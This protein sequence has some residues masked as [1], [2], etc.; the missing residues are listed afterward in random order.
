MRGRPASAITPGSP[1]DRTIG[2]FCIRK[3]MSIS[4][5]Y[6]MPEDVRDKLVT[7]YGPRTMRITPAAEAAFDKA[8]ANPTSTEQRL[9]NKLKA[10]RVAKAR[11]AA[12]ASLLGP[13]H[14][15]KKRKRKSPT[16]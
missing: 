4:G 13:N 3:T 6:R 12:Q 11:K 10:R 7:V 5:F 8:R 1:E 15:S 9:L 2:G 14:V 16:S